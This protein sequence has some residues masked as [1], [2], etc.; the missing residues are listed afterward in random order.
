MIQDKILEK[1]DGKDLVW[2]ERRSGVN[3]STLKAWSQGRQGMSLFNS[4]CVLQA[5]GYQYAIDDERTDDLQAMIAELYKIKN[6]TVDMIVARTGICKQSI[7]TTVTGE[8]SPSIDRAEKLIKA[9]GH[10]LS[11]RKAVKQ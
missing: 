9:M 2:L 11:I 6:V 5:L 7:W 10:T 8:R 1:M 4:E 3:I